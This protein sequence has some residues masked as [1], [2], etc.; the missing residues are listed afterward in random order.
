[1]NNDAE[2]RTIASA[3]TKNRGKFDIAALASYD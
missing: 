2:A 1:M 3:T